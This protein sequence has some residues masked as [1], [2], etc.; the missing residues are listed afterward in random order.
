[1]D[2]RNTKKESSIDQ[3]VAPGI[4]EEDSFGEDASKSDQDKG[5]TTQVTRLIYDEYDPS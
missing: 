5:D 4:D 2:K 3:K 1:M